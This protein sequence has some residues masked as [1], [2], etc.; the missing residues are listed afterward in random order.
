MSA[1]SFYPPCADEWIGKCSTFLPPCPTP[2]SIQQQMSP[3]HL[4]DFTMEEEKEY[5]YQGTGA[6]GT[7]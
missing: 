6:A 2:P 3:H 5:I 1:E 4:G 7:H